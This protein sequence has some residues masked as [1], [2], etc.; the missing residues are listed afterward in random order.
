[1]V[2]VRG[3][4]ARG[5]EGARCG[6]GGCERRW[7]PGKDA[8]RRPATPFIS[9]SSQVLWAARRRIEVRA[10]D[11][12]PLG[13]SPLRRRCGAPR[14]CRAAM[15][16]DSPSAMPA[17]FC[18]FPP[19]HPNPQRGAARPA[20]RIGRVDPGGRTHSA[21]PP[22]DE[23]SHHPQKPAKSLIRGDLGLLRLACGRGL[24]KLRRWSIGAPRRRPANPQGLGAGS[25]ISGSSQGSV[26]PLGKST[27]STGFPATHRNV[28]SPFRGGLGLLRLVRGRGSVK[29]RRWLTWEVG[30]RD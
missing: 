30:W 9:G 29:P 14:G 7:R 23:R 11:V 28:R 12:L 26:C 2:V 16:R 13:A 8:G 24:A 19:A 18:L 5:G 25:S 3:C 6:R 27:P 1:V 17:R 15:D 22:L 20:P 10:A 4:A 21:S